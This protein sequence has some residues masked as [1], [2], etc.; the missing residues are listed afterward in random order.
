MNS[1]LLK[2]NVLESYT[3]GLRSSFIIT[4]SGMGIA[5]AAQV[6]LARLM[7]AESYGIYIYVLTWMSILAMFSTLGFDS[8]LLKF[9]PIY[10]MQKEWGLFL[11]LLKRGIQLP[12]TTSCIATLFIITTVKLLPVTIDKNLSATLT[13]GC[14]A[15]PLFTLSK[16]FQS[17][18]RSLKHIV[19]AL[20]PAQILIPI[21]T[22]TVAWMFSSITDKQLDSATVM[23]LHAGVIFSVLTL[24]GFFII[25]L[26]AKYPIEPK[27]AV[28]RMMEWRCTARSL[29]FISGMH[30][31]LTQTD[32]LLL[33][34]LI[35]T[36]QAGI[37]A[38]AS[39][40]A[41]LVSFGL[42]ISNQI[43]A[44][45]ISELYH[46]N[47]LNRLQEVV[48]LGA[49]VSTIL[50]IGVILLIFFYGISILSLFGEEFVQGTKVLYILSIG[51]LVNAT[52]GSV[53]FI[54]T[55]TKHHKEAGII[56][57][58]SAFANIILNILLIPPFGMAGA[59]T[60]TC[61]TTIC[62]NISLWLFIKNKIGL[63]STIIY[64]IKKR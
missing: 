28:Y 24:F 2:N 14:I 54:M 22:I 27:K 33:G 12:L 50:A 6:I 30:L 51:Q 53:G 5:Y 17:I 46:S 11:G 37:Y 57:G 35:D 39:R 60:A 56:I 7:G 34:I 20:L 4:F 15:L 25:N 55:M 29:L 3:V 47:H 43:L 48:S 38:V 44:P 9:L 10:R 42:N 23:T 36:T 31:I 1:C 59:A 45:M 52:M 63:N 64:F 40:I 32:I 8:A 62:W 58:V 41:I 16:L 19:M 21:I 61:I 49:A 26:T 18:L 13:V